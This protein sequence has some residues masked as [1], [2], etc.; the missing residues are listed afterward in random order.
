MGESAVSRG[1]SFELAA[2][3][4]EEAAPLDQIFRGIAADDLLGESGEGD[5]GL[6]HLARQGDEQGDVAGTAPTVGLTLATA[7][8]ASRM[9]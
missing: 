6:R 1:E 7:S 9:G 2:L 4:V 8:F 3:P 5:I